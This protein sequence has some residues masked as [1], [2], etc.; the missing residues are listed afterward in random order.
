MSTSWMG[1]QPLGE[2]PIRFCPSTSI[3]FSILF[4]SWLRWFSASRDIEVFGLAR[5]ELERGARV[6]WVIDCE[7]L[8][9]E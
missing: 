1:Q 7:V 9:S 3:K 4:Q 8:L 2:G 5:K 6:V